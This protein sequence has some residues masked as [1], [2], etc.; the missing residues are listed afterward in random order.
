MSDDL[1][2]N[3]EIDRYLNEIAKELVEGRCIFIIGAGV[4]YESNAPLFKEII[5]KLLDI[6]LETDSLE[7]VDSEDKRKILEKLTFAQIAESYSGHFGMEQLKDKIGDLIKDKNPQPSQSH[8]HIALFAN[9][10][11]FSRIYTTNFD[12]LIEDSIG[13]KSIEVTEEDIDRL[14]DAETSHSVAVI[15]LHGSLKHT[16][17]MIVTEKEIFTNDA[18]ILKKLDVD[19]A[20]KRLIIFIGY[21]FGDED[22]KSMYIRRIR[23]KGIRG[24]IVF[25]VI[26][27]QMMTVLR[28]LWYNQ[29]G[30]NI[31]P[32]SADEFLSRLYEKVEHV[33]AAKILQEICDR[34][35]LVKWN[36]VLNKKDIVKEKF[37]NF[38]DLDAAYLLREAFQI[39]A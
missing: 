33:E 8:K 18:T 20:S 37:G 29:R 24:Y 23:E 5:E 9:K 31:I 28:Y 3:T 21:S 12:N 17:G 6:L 10:E 30:I 4:S 22:I 38:Y 34:I 26:H 7:G 15:H 32:I 1:V 39:K 11:Y 2:G 19:L 13:E 35:S 25:P 27:E 16:K 14:D 36:D